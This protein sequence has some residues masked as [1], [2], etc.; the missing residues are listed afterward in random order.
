[1]STTPS[2]VGGVS[3]DRL[4]QL[5]ERIER[6]EEEKAGIA[7]DIRDVYAEA[8]SAGLKPR[9]CARSSNCAKWIIKSA[10]NRK[11]CWNCINRQLAWPKLFCQVAI[12]RRF[13]VDRPLRLAALTDQLIGR[14][15]ISKARTHALLRHSHRR[16]SRESDFNLGPGYA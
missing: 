12:D 7:E 13:A 9:S 16:A 11:N 1:M 2:S 3:G 5:I 4:K 8:K 10:R 15:F 14:G 6:L